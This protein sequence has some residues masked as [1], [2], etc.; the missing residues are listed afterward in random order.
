MAA[1]VL[2]RRP[3]SRNNCFRGARH[4]RRQLHPQCHQKDQTA[5]QN[6]QPLQLRRHA[7]LDRFLDHLRK[8]DEVRIHARLCDGAGNRAVGM[9]DEI[10][11]VCHGAECGAGSCPGGL[12]RASRMLPPCVDLLFL[13]VAGGLLESYPRLPGGDHIGVIKQTAG[14]IA[15]YTLYRSTKIGLQKK[16]YNHATSCNRCRVRYRRS[17]GRPGTCTGILRVW[18]RGSR[19]AVRQ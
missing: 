9:L 4:Q 1:A 3:P 15:P 16:G 10:G 8:L 6:A 18:D 5:E 14:C 12:G 11:K 2:V 7:P 13:I 17:S 19:H